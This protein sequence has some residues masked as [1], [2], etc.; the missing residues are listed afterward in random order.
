MA[1][2]FLKWAG[3][4]RWIT[5]RTLPIPDHFNMYYE[6]FLGSGAVYFM[7]E[8]RRAFLSDINKDLI[9]LYQTIAEQPDEF[10]EALRLHGN[11]H[12]KDYY[13]RTRGSV[14]DTALERAA[15]FLYLNRTCWNGLYRVNREGKFNVPIGTKNSVALDTDNFRSIADL[16]KTAQIR[17]ADFEEVI[18]M[19]GKDDLLFVDPPYTVL[20]N[21]NNFLKYNEDI[22]SWNDQIRLSKALLKAKD[23]GVQIM[24][25][26]ANHP[27]VKR[28]YEP[29]GRS[30]QLTR[31]SVLAGDSSKRGTTTE[32]I[33]LANIS[34][35]WLGRS[36]GGIG[37]R[38][39]P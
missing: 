22:F 34:V 38:L 33:F 13:Y 3:G 7:I 27:T 24:V 5:R 29:L 37:S 12:C 20:H 25:T 21:N 16:L 10:G 23:R 17:Q 31:K 30:Y 6:P 4:K 32:A 26:N 35:E 9:E 28:L 11:N 15:R 1:T 19:T 36:T 39:Y 14:P 18:D 8:P 2:P